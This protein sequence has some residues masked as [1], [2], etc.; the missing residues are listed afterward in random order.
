MVVRRGTLGT[1]LALSFVA[2]SGVAACAQ[3]DE[4]D[5]EKRAPSDPNGAEP[6]AESD[7]TG[8]GDAQGG[9]AASQGRGTSSGA[10]SQ[11]GSPHTAGSDATPSNTSN[12]AGT[13]G[14]PP[15]AGG[16][17]GSVTRDPRC[18]DSLAVPFPDTGDPAPC[19]EPGLRCDYALSCSSGPQLLTVTCEDGAWQGP[20]G[21][22]HPYDYCPNTQE[23]GRHPAVY[24][25]DGEWD[26]E[27]FE[28]GVDHGPG[29]CPPEAPELGSDCF[30]VGGTGGG[31]DREPCGYPC[32]SDPARW[33]VFECDNPGG[34]SR[35]ALMGVWIAD[36][37]CD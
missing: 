28:L 32:P 24:C 27:T 15:A 9:R 16:A 26:V 3:G 18:P 25:E 11:G 14:T 20:T 31:P 13:G 17:A 6:A 35:G 4:R 19:T 21:C 12:S 2:G 8:A 7:Q 29:A 1:T 5:V 36:G 22:D 37:A 23:M 10:S 30:V 33:T 34:E